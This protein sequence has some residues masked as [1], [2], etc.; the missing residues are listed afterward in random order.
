MNE[1]SLDQEPHEHGRV[2]YGNLARW[3]PIAL[4][5]VMIVAIAYIALNRPEK[6]KLARDLIGKPAPALSLA[7][8]DGHSA[9]LQSMQGQVVVL[10]FWAAWCDPCVA[11]MPAFQAVHAENLDDVRIIG[12]NLKTDQDDAAAA[13]LSTTGVTYEIAKDTGGS[14]IFHGDIEDAFGATGPY[15]MTIIIAADGTVNSVKFG[16]LDQKQIEK[17]IEKA[18][19]S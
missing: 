4:T 5:L 19:R 6:N 16:A 13:L 7:F 3:S 12:I 10:N 17:A 8:T 11:E 9:T 2:G 18:L 15:P 14:T 1:A